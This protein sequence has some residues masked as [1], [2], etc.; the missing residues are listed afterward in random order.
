MGH[1]AERQRLND[2]TLLF[3]VAESLHQLTP[4]T[5]MKVRSI[6]IKIGSDVFALSWSMLW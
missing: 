1:F 4:Y 2:E 5:S 3:S 6:L